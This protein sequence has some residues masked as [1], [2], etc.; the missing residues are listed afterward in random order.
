MKFHLIKNTILLAFLAVLFSGCTETYP[1]LTNTYEEIIVIEATLTN[2]LKNQ[3]IK[4][5]KTSKFEDTEVA[6]ESGAKVVVRDDQGNEYLFV[7][8]SGVYKSQVAFQALPDAKYTLEVTTKDG[9]IYQSNPQTLT[10]VNPIQSVVPALA[11]NKD[12]ETGVQINVNNYDPTKSSNY[13]RYEYEETFK[14]VAPKWNVYKII[15]TSLQ[16]V[17]LINN[18]PA[19]KTCYSTKKSTD[20]IL[21]N[22]NDLTEDRVNLPIRFID[23]NDYIIGHRY[24]ILVKQYIESLEAYTF[25]KTIKDMS[26]SSSILNPKQPGIIAGNIR[27][28]N[29][30]ATKVIGFFDVSSYSESRIFFNYTDFF[31]T[32]PIPYFNSCDDVP[33]KFCFGT[34][35]CEGETMIYNINK[36]LM[37]YVSGAG[38]NYTL[39][40][41][42]CGDCTSFSSNIKPSFWID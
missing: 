9:K 37:T 25:H 19:T 15:S 33:F 26:S 17:D 28:I 8:S 5:T 7:E 22:T 42:A 39:V 11:V 13:Y 30:S 40:D 6:V 3:E 18:D 38:S 32:S 34:E 31:P 16:T 2:E 23:K 21:V 24:S 20:I 41:V 35:D 27:C 36:N 29:D 4:I 12:N 14:I 1:L 10:K